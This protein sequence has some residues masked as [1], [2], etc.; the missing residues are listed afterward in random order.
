MKIR[1]G[2]IIPNV[3]IG[4]FLLGMTNKELEEYIS[5]YTIE[6]RANDIKVYHIENAL[7]FFDKTDSLTQVGVS[8]GFEGK[9]NDAIGV[10][11]TINELNNLGFECYED[12]Y[13]YLI[14]GV[15]G[16]AFELG[17]TDSDYDWNEKEAPIEWIF[18]YQ[19]QE[20]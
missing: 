11:N 16:I 14:S 12:K 7:F 5:E 8:V 17:D 10:G 2:N 20:N 3:G 6:H 13:D 9:F 1:D 18:V 15:D 4:Q 19:T